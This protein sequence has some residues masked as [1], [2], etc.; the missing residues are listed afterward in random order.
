MSTSGVDHCAHRQAAVLRGR[1]HHAL[2]GEVEGRR[3]GGSLHRKRAVPRRRAWRRSLPAGR[4]ARTTLAGAGLDVRKTGGGVVADGPGAGNRLAVVEAWCLRVCGR[5]RCRAWRRRSG[6]V[7]RRTLPVVADARQTVPSDGGTS[8]TRRNWAISALASAIGRVKGKGQRGG[9]VELTVGGIDDLEGN[10]VGGR[11]FLRC[12]RWA[13][14]GRTTPAIAAD[15]KAS[16]TSGIV[17]ALCSCS[18]RH[19]NLP[20]YARGIPSRNARRRRGAAVFG[21]GYS[22]QA[23]A[24]LGRG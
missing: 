22:R 14:R 15:G 20:V 16:A 9:A 21:C 10:A 23:P 13:C 2:A 24:V 11:R 19:L 18:K 6:L 8:I 1:Q 17:P 12:R 5:R 4:A 3:D 7:P